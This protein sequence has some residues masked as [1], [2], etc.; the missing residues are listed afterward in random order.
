LWRGQI[1]FSWQPPPGPCQQWQREGPLAVLRAHPLD[2]WQL[3]ADQ[4]ASLRSAPGRAEPYGAPPP[5]P[6]PR[7]GLPLQAFL[8]ARFGETDDLVP[9][10]PAAGVY[11]PPSESELRFVDELLAAP[12]IR[13]APEGL[14][15]ETRRA[16]IGGLAALI[17]YS[18]EYLNDCAGAAIGCWVL[19][20][21]RGPPEAPY[22]L[23]WGTLAVLTE[24]GAPVAIEVPRPLREGGS[25]RLGAELWQALGARALV[26]G[27]REVPEQPLA[28]P[29]AT[30]NLRTPFQAMHEAIHGALSEAGSPPI[31]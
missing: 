16:A 13:R 26:V 10:P 25:W 12:L 31:L 9:Q 28:D 29:A 15:P 14:E 17:G 4:G 24:H 1:Q 8:R 21:R 27:A 19:A 18:V 23:G 11:T 20:E 7:A 30:F 6:P 22:G 5:A 3:L 2:L